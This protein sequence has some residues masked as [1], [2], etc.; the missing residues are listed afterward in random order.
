MKDVPMSEPRLYVSEIHPMCS[1]GNHQMH[2]RLKPWTS[3]M[4]AIKCADCGTTVM[5]R[6]P[7]HISIPQGRRYAHQIALQINRKEI[8][9]Q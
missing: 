9:I 3:N 1:G 2:V 7:D 6:I 8:K 5:I 4:Q